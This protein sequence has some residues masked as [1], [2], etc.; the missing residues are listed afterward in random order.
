M[1]DSTKETGVMV[2]LLERFE[3]QR[4]P[5]AQ[6]IKAKVD[7]GEVLSEGDMAFLSQVFADAQYVKPLLHNQP[8]WQPLV[9]RIVSLYKEIMDKA[10]EN[11]QGSKPGK[12]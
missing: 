2:A 8:K 10:L 6:A 3:T 11:E 9:S 1:T 7:K 4:L 5:Q 12:S